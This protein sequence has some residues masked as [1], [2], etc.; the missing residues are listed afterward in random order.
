LTAKKYKRLK[1]LPETITSSFGDLTENFIMIVWGQS[2]NGKSSFLM[3]LLNILLANGKALYVALEEGHEASIQ[4]NVVRSLEKTKAKGAIM[5]ADCTM[6]YDALVQ[7]LH[8]KRKIE[9]FI[10]IDSLQYW[11]IDYEKYK[12]LK[13]LFPTKTFIFISHAKGKTPDGKT[14]DKIRYD[15]G[16]KVFVHGY[17]AFVKSRY[18]GNKPF[19]IWE[20]GA[21]KH[22]GEEFDKMAEVKKEPRRKRNKTVNSEQ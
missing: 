11:N 6:S 16:I 1:N 8:D 3:Q 2:G 17:I 5:F 18:G 12:A 22:W 10:I 9:R 7:R 14:A 20:E 21:K 13:E 15:A 4:A 19:V